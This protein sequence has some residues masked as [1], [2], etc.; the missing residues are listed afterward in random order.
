MHVLPLLNFLLRVLSNAMMSALLHDSR[1][2]LYNNSIDC[3]DQRP[4]HGLET[5]CHRGKLY[6][7][8]EIPLNLKLAKEFCML[9]RCSIH[10][11]GYDSSCYYQVKPAL[12]LNNLSLYS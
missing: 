2:S 1:L 8:T 7:G 9:S 10:L 12:P 6:R 3:K 11:D 4:I 5:G